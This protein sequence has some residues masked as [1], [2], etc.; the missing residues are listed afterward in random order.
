V[1]GIASSILDLATFF[2]KIAHKLFDKSTGSP[3]AGGDCAVDDRFK[4]LEGD[5]LEYSCFGLK[6]FKGNI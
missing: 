5:I 4:L 3:L 1:L 6:P 2:G